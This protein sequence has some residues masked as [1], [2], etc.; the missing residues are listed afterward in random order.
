VSH[1]AG[2]A[3]RRATHARFVSQRLRVSVVGRARLRLFADGQ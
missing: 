1:A 3:G 2:F